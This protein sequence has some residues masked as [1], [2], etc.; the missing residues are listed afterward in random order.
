MK[1]KT[2][3]RALKPSVGEGSLHSLWLIK[4]HSLLHSDG[5]LVQI[6]GWKNIFLL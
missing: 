3:L 4:Y 6:K 1:K 2:C 5:S